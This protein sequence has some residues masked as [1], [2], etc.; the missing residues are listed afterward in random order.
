MHLGCKTAIALLS[1]VAQS[2]AGEPIVN[3]Y[4]YVAPSYY[5]T[6]PVIES[7]PYWPAPAAGGPVVVAPVVPPH[8]ALLVPS[9]GVAVY[10]PAFLHTDVVPYDP[11]WP[12]AYMGLPGGYYRE[13][14]HVRPREVEYSLKTYGAMGVPRVQK[15]EVEYGKRGLKVESKW[16]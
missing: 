2:S 5:L 13:R 4:T 16:K 12:Y 6:P 7:V 10:E 14:L 9:P 15:Y 8:G 11:V 1:I 3:G